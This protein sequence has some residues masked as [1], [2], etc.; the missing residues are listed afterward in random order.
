[1][2]GLTFASRSLS[3]MED[4][5]TQAS[6]SV[7]RPSNHQ[8]RKGNIMPVVNV[9]VVEG[10]F[11]TQQKE[12]MISKITDVMVSL[13][14]EFMREKTYVLIEEIKSGDWGIGG[15]AMTAEIIKQKAAQMKAEADGIK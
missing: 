6:L 12:E 15:K 4:C 13:E 11:S 8:P 3:V 14:G 10:V 2:I 7:A 1:M 5:P 9:S